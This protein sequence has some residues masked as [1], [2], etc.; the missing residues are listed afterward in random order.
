MALSLQQIQRKGA[1]SGSDRE[2]G[3]G[4]GIGIGMGVV[5]LGGEEDGGA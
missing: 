1:D 5:A 3:G 4:G 2:V